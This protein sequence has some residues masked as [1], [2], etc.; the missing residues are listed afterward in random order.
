M[1]E[2][3]RHQVRERAN[4]RCE[5]CRLKQEHFRLFRHQIE[6]I[7][8]RKHH[9]TDELENFALACIRCNLGKSSNLTGVDQQSGEIVPLFNP[10]QELWDDHFQYHGALIVGKTA[11]GR[12]TVDVLNMNEPTRVRLRETLLKN[13]ELD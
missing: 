12:V 10:R 5:Y 13:G 4:H 9:G 6:H 8:P 1:N 2:S 7:I 3:T 11:I